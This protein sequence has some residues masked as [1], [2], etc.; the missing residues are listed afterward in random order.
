MLFS[1]LRLV[2]VTLLFC[3]PLQPRVFAGRNDSAHLSITAQGLFD[4]YSKNE[5]AAD[6]RFKNRE[7]VVGGLIQKIGRD[8]SDVPYIMLKCTEASPSSAVVITLSNG[9]VRCVFDPQQAHSLTHLQVGRTCSVYG[10]VV[11]K[12]NHEVIVANCSL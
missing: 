3:L 4:E 10:K 9:G 11:G 6:E 7:I 1:R 8:S 5:I 12:H 2:V